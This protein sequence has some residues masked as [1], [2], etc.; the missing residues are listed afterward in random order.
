[1]ITELSAGGQPLVRH[2]VKRLEQPK[3]ITA[4]TNIAYSNNKQFRNLSLSSKFTKAEAG[5]PTDSS[6]NAHVNTWIQY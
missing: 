6:E 5:R 3:S 1:M 4:V 2:W